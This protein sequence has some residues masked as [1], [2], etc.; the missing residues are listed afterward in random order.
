MEVSMAIHE[1]VL[2]DALV[3]LAE[4][5]KEQYLELAAT[6]N[7]V[8]ALH[9]SADRLDPQFS[10]ILARQTNFPIPIERRNVAI[11]RLDEI[12]RRLNTDSIH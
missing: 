2:R 5:C 7:E 8:A 3:A 9:K 6:I 1:S 11:Q 12:I 4:Q 10:E